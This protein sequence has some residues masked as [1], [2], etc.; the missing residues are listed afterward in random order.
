MPGADLGE[1]AYRFIDYLGEA[2][3]SIWQMLPV[4]PAG[5]SNSPYAARSAFA[6][7]P[8]LLSMAALADDGYLDRVPPP[9]SPGGS[10]HVDFEA[11]RAY[12]EP[13]L[14]TAFKLF[15]EHGRLGELLAFEAPRPW[16]HTYAVFSA[17][18]N[19]HG[20]P[21]WL[22]DEHLR[23]PAGVEV[24]EGTSLA[25]EVAYHKFLQFCFDEQWERLRTYAHARGIRLWGDLPIFVDRDS[26]DVWANQHL[27]KLDED[28]NPTVVSGVP[29]DVF[30]ATGQRWG[31]PV[32]DWDAME[33]DGYR[34]WIE[35]LRTTF[36][37]F[38]AV[39]IDHFRGFESA[40]E[41][42]AHEETAI[43]GQWVPGPGD[44]LFAALEAE[45]GE[46]PILVEDLG[47]ITEEVRAL[48]DRL[49]YPG[50]AVLQFAFEG[51]PDNPYLPRNQV[52][53]SVVFTGTHDNDTTLGWWESLPEPHRD[54]VR[55]ELGIDGSDIVD[56]MIRAAYASVGRTVLIPMQ[57]VLKLG[58]EARM[59][60][61]AVL[62]G[63]WGWRFEWPQVP[64]GRA[65]WLRELAIATGRLPAGP[66]D[67]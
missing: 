48:R 9:P 34:W 8:L 27:Y 46:L 23:T 66:A 29:P 50:M 35:R 1:D 39:R 63:N 60:R 2:G 11:R 38:D 58:G 37:L 16:L 62:D 3:Q 49:G 13:L 26:A 42:P 21:W 22:W 55:M 52:E 5:P 7:D 33:S 43:H 20:E 32:Y 15:V 57:D 25:G 36:Q 6:G 18:R 54:V 28:G 59:N 64:P 24:A 47:I 56:D 14:R 12:K 44:R 45:L 4:G 65:A 61:P 19:S 51:G 10:S 30:S 53:N 31:N 41:I 40:W 17:L 67:V